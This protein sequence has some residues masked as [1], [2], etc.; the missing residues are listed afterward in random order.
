MA[1]T[2]KEWIGKT[3]DAMPHPRVRLRILKAHDEKCGIC[4]GVIW[5]GDAWELDHIRRL[6]DGGQNRERNMHP[7]HPSCHSRKTGE[8]NAQQA[9]ED[10]LRKKHYGIKRPSSVLS[11]YGRA[12]DGL[13]RELYGQP[14]F[15]TYREA[16]AEAERRLR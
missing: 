9:E 2:V 7:A 12:L 16:R 4:G 10:R 6:K 11:K 3:D 14:G 8:E 15:E 13:T 5:P 1:R